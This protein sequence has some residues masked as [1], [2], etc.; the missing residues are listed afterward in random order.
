MKILQ[1]RL[2][3][4]GPF[5]DTLIDLSEG[6]EGIHIIYGPNEAGKS[7]AL[8]AL[9]Q[10]LYGIPDRSSDNF[11][12]P[13]AKMRIGGVLR[14]SDGTVIEI[15]RRKGR[16]N[17][18][19]ESHDE[20]PVDE[21]L[22]QKF[23]GDI[24]AASFATMFGISHTDL[25]QGGE[26]IIRG[27]GNVGQALFAAGSGISDLRQIRLD[28]QA[29]ADSL[30]APSA[31]KRPINE[32]M[33]ELK[34]NQKD[35]R[36]A[37]LPGQEWERHDT[38]LRTAMKRRSEVDVE[39]RAK[40]TEQHRL[41]RIREA[42]PLIA[43]RK[44]RLEEL[45]SFSNAVLLPDD[46]GERR[47]DHLSDLRIAKN[48]Q[49]Q[50]IKGIKDVCKALEKLEVTEALL[51][52]SKL[53]EYIYRDLGSYQKAFKDRPKLMTERDVLWGEAKEILS[54]LRDDL[55]LEE[56]EKLRLKRT[57]TVRIK[58]LG[59]HYQ[60]LMIKLESTREDIPRLELQGEKLQKELDRLETPRPIDD[61][62]RAIDGANRYGA[63]EDHYHTEYS[64]I[65]GA[66]H[67]LEVALNKQTLWAGTLEELEKLPLPSIETIDTFEDRLN[68][69]QRQVDRIRSEKK[70]IEEKLTEIDGEIEELRLEQEIPTEEDL[71]LARKIRDQGWQL[72]LQALKEGG[73]Q[74]GG[75]LTEAYESSVK[76]ADEIAD[77]L[78]READRVAKKAKLIAEGDTNKARLKNLKV[79]LETAETKLEDKNKEWLMVWETMGISPRTPRE[80]RFWAQNMNS[81]AEETSK[82]RQRE[83]KAKALGERMEACCLELN[84]CLKSLGEPWAEKHET[85]SDLIKRSQ[86]IADKERELKN[87]RGQIEREKEQKEEEAK[88]LKLRL[89]KIEEDL[90]KWQKQWEDAVKPIGLD[91]EAIPEQA[92]AVLDDLK[93]L[94]DKLREAEKLHK[95]IKGIDRDAEAFSGKVMGLA[96]RMASDLKDLPAEH[97]ATELNARL[98]RSRTA[99]SQQLAMEKQRRQ[100]EDKL[101]DAKQRIAHIESE[102]DVICEEAGCSDYE[103]LPNAERRSKM[104][105]QIESDLEEL[106]ERLRKLGAGATVEEFVTEAQKVDP[107]G[108]DGQIEKLSQE[109]K[110]LNE[111]KSELDQTIG[112]ERNELSKMDGSARAAEL[113]EET[114]RILARLETDAVR[115]ARFRLA[116]AVLA[117]A[118]ERYREKHQGPILK[119]TNE[120]FTHLT[121]GSFEGIRVEFDDQGNPVLVGVRPGG[122]EMVGVEGMSDGTTDQLYLAL[123]LASLEAYL[124][125]NEPIPF[126][127]DDILIK[128]DN[129]RATAA[130]EVLSQLAGKT[131]VI[132]FTHHRHLG[133]LAE[134]NLDSSLLF[135]HSLG[136]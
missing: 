19:R 94:F 85:L 68:E 43:R 93:T 56:A 116:S 126:I 80:M 89:N 101:R 103:E 76:D 37:Q 59:T 65:L 8:R 74:T 67:S 122:K 1:M 111:E 118:I 55:T 47:R 104:R 60:G 91:A 123:R 22:F 46:F 78:R 12:H 97:V 39:L 95:R 90:T 99:K 26:E 136:I 109:I 10:M 112:E 7:S 72:I 82:I 38:A 64:E 73:E 115:Y 9:R 63:L 106:E 81:L 23:M 130:L 17:T 61:L 42:L 36:E 45:K 131:Q 120:L 121:L 24:D 32:A 16:V 20:K 31:S 13:Y 102:L 14:H 79:E 5:T 98:T 127:V 108:I 113:A 100:E 77:R 128:F 134:A 53:I 119:R 54:S 70:N 135:K 52:N 35:I 125:K 57:E 58:E 71:Q 117:Q 4:F 29:Q 50:A 75:T 87:K 129:E 96:E 27:G 133:E 33:A 2:L 25:V 132:F 86:E 44:E 49:D 18:L 51:E 48:D 114:Q 124:E 110:A 69:A 15:I 66:R 28:L 6:E 3:A 107:D 21:A 84:G 11:L 30:F 41:E 92:N 83:F 34:K 62:K 88:A 105:R 40:Q